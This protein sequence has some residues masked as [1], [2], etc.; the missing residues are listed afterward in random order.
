MTGTYPTNKICLISCIGNIKTPIQP[1]T[2]YITNNNNN[3]NVVNIDMGGITMNGVNDPD[4]FTA[5]ILH[6][7]KKK[8]KVKDAINLNSVERLI[9]NNNTLSVNSIK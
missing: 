7:V 1:Y 4:E 3:N 2:K 6:T 9:S 5:Q 8:Q